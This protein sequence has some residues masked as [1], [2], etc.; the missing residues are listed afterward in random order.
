MKVQEN[1]F[2][3]LSIVLSLALSGVGEAFAHT[4]TAEGQVQKVDNATSEVVI[5]Q[6]PI[7]ARAVYRVRDSA[8]LKLFKAGDRV[9][10]DFDH[11]AAGYVITRIRKK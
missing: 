9:K 11:D 1:R 10:F 3:A 5:D 7:K 8:I 2:N 6:V 4:A